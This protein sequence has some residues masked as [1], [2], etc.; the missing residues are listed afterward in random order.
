MTSSLVSKRRWSNEGAASPPAFRACR[1]GAA[2]ALRTGS[3]A[4]PDLRGILASGL[5]ARDRGPEAFRAADALESSAAAGAQ[6]A[7]RVRFLLSALGQCAAVVGT[8][9]AL[10]RQNEDQ[11]CVSGAARGGENPPLDR[12]CG[13]GLGSR[14]LCALY[15]ACAPGQRSGER[16]AC[17]RAQ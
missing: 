17:Q 1:S 4:R 16:S 5:D 11:Y 7:R 8:G 9:R 15:H 13:Q 14:L 3:L 2:R 12:A 6:D 10:L